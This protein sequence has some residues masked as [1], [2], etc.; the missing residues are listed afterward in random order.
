M[1]GTRNENTRQSKQQTF[2]NLPKPEIRD[3]LDSR[4]NLEQDYKGGNTTHHAK[5]TKSKKR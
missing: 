1:K 4:K 5:A 3:N 2:S